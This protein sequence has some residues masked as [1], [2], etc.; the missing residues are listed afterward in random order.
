MKDQNTQY[1]I[2]QVG[3]TNI[4][5][6]IKTQREVRYKEI[7]EDLRSKMSLKQKKL[8]DITQ[9][10]GPS[11]WLTTYP[12]IEYGFDP[13]K[14]HFWDSIRIRYGWDIKNMPI[15]CSCGAKLNYQ[16]C[17][18]CKKGD[19]ITMRHNDVRYLTANILKGVLNDVEVELQLLP[20]TGE[21]LRYQTAIRGEEARLD[22]RARRL[23]EKGQQTFLDVKVFDPKASRYL[24][25]SIQQCYNI[26]EKENKRN[27]N[28]QILQIGA[29]TPLVFSLYGR[30][31]RECKKF[32]SILVELVS[33]K[34]NISKSVVTNWIIT[35]ISY[36]LL[37]AS[38]LCA[39]GSRPQVSRNNIN[40]G[41]DVAM[42]NDLSNID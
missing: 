11:N 28:K 15:T 26:N 33:I 39:R 14:Q 19:F 2:D 10:Q 7:L 27:Y 29:F 30:M 18:S 20:L 22:I 5:S 6:T 41:S 12:L 8:N 24:N 13:N 17:M 35:K 9:E 4:K 21:N 23:R 31:G 25:T 42:S 32:Y 38:L 40:F 37:K 3:I 36:A 1:S 16:H 34:Q